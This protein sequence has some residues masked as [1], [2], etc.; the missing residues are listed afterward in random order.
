MAGMRARVAK[1]FGDPGEELTLEVSPQNS[2]SRSPTISPTHRSSKMSPLTRKPLTRGISS[3]NI[4]NLRAN[5]FNNYDGVVSGTSVSEKQQSTNKDK[6]SLGGEEEEDEGTESS[7]EKPSTSFKQTALLAKLEVL[8]SADRAIHHRRAS[9]P[10]MHSDEK[11]HVVDHSFFD[12]FTGQA[13]AAAEYMS[14]I[15]EGM[16]MDDEMEEFLS[17]RKRSQSFDDK[18]GLG[19]H[20][21]H[22]GTKHNLLLHEL[23][24]Y[25][26]NLYRI[27]LVHAR[28]KTLIDT[29]DLDVSEMFG[30][31]D[32]DD[33]G[34]IGLEELHKL[35]SKLGIVMKKID[36]GCLMDSIDLTGNGECDADEFEDWLTIPIRDHPSRKIPGDEYNDINLLKRQS[37]IYDPKWLERVRVFWTLVDA[38]RSGSISMEEY[39]TLHLNLQRTTCKPSKFDVA[40]ARRLAI[41]EWEFDSQGQDQMDFH[42]FMLSFFQMGDAWRMGMGDVHIDRYM[43]FMDMMEDNLVYHDKKKDVKMWAWQHNLMWDI[44]LWEEIEADEKGKY[45]SDEKKAE[46]HS[47]WLSDNNASKDITGLLDIKMTKLK[48]DVRIKA[49]NEAVNARRRMSRPWIGMTDRQKGRRDGMMS[50][51]E[52]AAAAAEAAE[53]AA[54]A[55]KPKKGNKGSGLD[56]EA[57]AAA[58][59]EARKARREK[60]GRA[61]LKKKEGMGSNFKLDE[62]AEAKEEYD[63]YA[64]YAQKRPSGEGDRPLGEGDDLP[65]LDDVEANHA[66]TKLQARMRGRNARRKSVLEAPVSPEASQASASLQRAARKSVIFTAVSRPNREQKRK[67]SVRV[68]RIDPKTG[69]PKYV[70]VDPNENRDSFNDEQESSES[71]KDF[72]RRVT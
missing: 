56:M 66:A 24:L 72:V 20:E 51:L 4:L 38:D 19:F 17:H 47:D 58:R 26:D 63:P 55:T 3:P 13:Q 28:L 10:H 12:K 35:V 22:C 14:H 23:R 29:H 67:P 48:Q 45:I 54:K 43:A 69:K 36:V 30:L 6:D 15:K 40:E 27:D 65:A 9:I 68:R 21:G 33:S 8:Q 31:V 42:L 50:T 49:A 53:A 71:Q 64:A 61:W 57:R 5:S 41:R 7:S 37:I 11:H 25:F 52:S 18:D 16:E 32:E 34:E 1:D 2:D 60:H 46:S 70:L 62:A 39:I 59:A 44:R